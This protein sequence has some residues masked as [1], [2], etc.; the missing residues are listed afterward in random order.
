MRNL[1][2]RIGVL[3]VLF[4]LILP[5]PSKA[6]NTGELK[7]NVYTDAKF[8]FQL[9][10]LDNWKM[11]SEKEPSLLRLVMTQKNYKAS[12]IPGST[13]Y[14]TSIPTIIILADTTSL[15][16]KQVAQSLLEQKEFLANRNEF[17][18]KLDLIANSEYLGIHD[19]TVDSIPARDYTLKQP[20][21]KTGEDIR[22]HDSM[23]GSSVIIQDFLAGHVVIFK[24]DKNIYILQFSCEREFFYPTNVE[25]QKILASWK[26]SPQP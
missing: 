1:R 14:T 9:T 23:Y 18:L 22:V 11:K 19:I 21:K 16:L 8:G 24:R 20:Y 7:K 3:S 17:L 12:N 4:L 26:F 25:F 15:T 13:Q 10:G 5:H 6:E 2:I